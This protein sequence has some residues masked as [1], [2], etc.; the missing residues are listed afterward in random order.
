MSWRIRCSPKEEIKGRDTATREMRRRQAAFPSGKTFESWREDISSIPIQTQRAL[1]T[2]EWVARA[3]N[4]S[5]SGPS[6]TGKSHFCEALGHRAIDGG[7]K[8]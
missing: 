7:L 8:V 6:G 2:L 4:L 5:I 1:M 3:E